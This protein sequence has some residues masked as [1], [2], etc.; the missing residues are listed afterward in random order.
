MRTSWRAPLELA[1]S[2]AGTIEDQRTRVR[3]PAERPVDAGEVAC[4]H[5]LVGEPALHRQA[6]E[7]DQAPEFA[8]LALAHRPDIPA[9]SAATLDEPQQRQP[10]DSERLA[11]VGDPLDQLIV[12]PVG[13]GPRLG[14]HA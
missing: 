4:A 5:L 11:G 6:A 8:G 1:S 3:L 10:L 12:Q 7:L 14:D 9:A 13:A 2:L